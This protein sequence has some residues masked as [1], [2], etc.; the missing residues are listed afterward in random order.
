MSIKNMNASIS[1]SCKIVWFLS[2]LRL[3]AEAGLIRHFSGGGGVNNVKFLRLA[4][5]LA[6][7]LKNFKC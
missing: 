6:V 3:V 4:L 7:F 5:L 2:R 1:V